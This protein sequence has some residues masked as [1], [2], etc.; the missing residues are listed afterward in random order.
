MI[1]TRNQSRLS[2]LSMAVKLLSDIAV[3]R[4]QRKKHESAR[5]MELGEGAQMKLNLSAKA[6][7]DDKPVAEMAVKTET[8]KEVA[9]P[10]PVA[11]GTSDM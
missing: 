10:E 11:N 5:Y 4:V 9:G 8:A 7:Y 1:I 2:Q 3:K 6:G